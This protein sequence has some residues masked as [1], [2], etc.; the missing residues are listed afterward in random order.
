MCRIHI[1]SFI[2]FFIGYDTGKILRQGL[3]QIVIHSSILI[4]EYGRKQSRHKQKH[5]YS[6][7]LRHKISHAL[8]IRQQRLVFRLYQSLVKHKD[9]GW[10][11][12]HT[13]DNTENHAFGH[14]HAQIHTQRKTHEAKSNKSCHR[15]HGT[16]HH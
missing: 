8:H 10:K 16:A 11:N 5:K 3:I 1:E 15:C 4:T 13:C 9:H 14:H 2:Q 7:M 6:V 12:G